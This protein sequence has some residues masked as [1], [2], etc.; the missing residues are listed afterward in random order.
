MKYLNIKITKYLHDGF[1]IDWPGDQKFQ[2]GE[3]VN[4]K[5]EQVIYF[6]PFKIPDDQPKADIIFISHEHFDHCEPE[7]I[8]K[9]L[10]DETIVVGNTK[11]QKVLERFQ[12]KHFEVVKVSDQKGVNGLIYTC[13]PAYNITKFR[14]Q[15]SIFTP[16]KRVELVFCS[17][18]IFIM[19]EKAFLFIIWVIP[20]STKI[21]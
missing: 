6:D 5:F 2:L 14:D 10:K 8:E 17:N 20:I 18:L 3:M 13:L 7:S 12:L 21:L 11:V 4:G 16:K 19:K 1:R 15:E 9:L